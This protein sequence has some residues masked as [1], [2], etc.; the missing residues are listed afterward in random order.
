MLNKCVPTLAARIMHELSR[1]GGTTAEGLH[2]LKQAARELDLA[3]FEDR[4]S[5]AALTEG[6]SPPTP[7]PTRDPA[8][9]GAN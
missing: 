5:W 3:G 4:P 9:P 2:Q 8:E 6:G 1:S 7:A